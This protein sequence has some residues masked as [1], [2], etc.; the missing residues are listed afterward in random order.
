M[1]TGNA[2]TTVTQRRP[3]CS[4]VYGLV[5]QILKNV[6]TLRIFHWK[7]PAR[8]TVWREFTFTQSVVNQA[9]AS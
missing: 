2:G 7:D 4:I 8:P 3:E 9:K 1:L 6:S 5:E